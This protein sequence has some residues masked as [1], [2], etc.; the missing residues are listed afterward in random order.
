MSSWHFSWLCTAGADTMNADLALQRTT[1][2]RTGYSARIKEI[3]Q[4]RPQLKRD[5]GRAQC[6]EAVEPAGA[7]AP[8][9]RRIWND[10]DRAVVTNSEDW[11]QTIRLKCNLVA[12]RVSRD[13][14]IS[15]ISEASKTKK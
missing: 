1:K 2:F 4:Q 8:W 14:S 7:T 3:G 9:S 10:G 13:R 11:I 15:H 6:V 5:R 12:H